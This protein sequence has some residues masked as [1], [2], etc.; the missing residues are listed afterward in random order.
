MWASGPV[1]APSS[2]ATLPIPV[3]GR[4]RVGAEANLSADEAS[5]GFKIHRLID[6]VPGVGPSQGS[7][8]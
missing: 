3:H 1:W 4:T 6:L 5:G 7:Y 8:R 2:T